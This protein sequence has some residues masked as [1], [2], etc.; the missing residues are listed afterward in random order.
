[1]CGRYSITTPVEAMRSLFEFEAL[2]NLPPRYNVAPTQEVPIVRRAEAGG[3]RELAL[4]RWGLVPAWAK[5]ASMAAR[6]INARAETVADK[7][8]FRAAFAQRRCLVPADGFYEWQKRDGA[9][10]PYRIA[11]AD[12]QAF[13]FAGLWERWA[14]GGETLESCTIITTEANARLAPIHSRM[15]VILRREDYEPWL[16]TPAKESRRLLP[17]LAPR[18]DEALTAYAVSTRVNNVTN[19]DAAVIE[20]LAGQPAMI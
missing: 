17:L 13:A 5:D 7:P 16:A 14:R 1:M 3:R 19:D 2:P 18:D 12:G 4:A 6:L 8:S 10:Q 9:K 11:R 20:P 15:P